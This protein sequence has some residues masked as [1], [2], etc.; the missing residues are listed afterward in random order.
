MRKKLSYGPG[1]VDLVPHT[2]GEGRDLV[3]PV[4]GGIKYYYGEKWDD[5]L[6]IRFNKRDKTFEIR[7]LGSLV[8]YPQMTNKMNVEV[9][10]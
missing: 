6:E 4:S 7:A 1:R 8:V 5:Y 10:R 2:E 9:K 3:Q